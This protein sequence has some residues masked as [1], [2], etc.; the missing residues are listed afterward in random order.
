MGEF[1]AGVD[2]E[3]L[4]DVA[5]VVIDRLGTQEQ[6]RRRLSDGYAT[7]ELERD[8]QFLGCWLVNRGWVAPSQRL[9]GGGELDPR[10]LGPRSRT[11]LLERVDRGR[12]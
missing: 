3:L 12:S 7:G 10:A 5:E 11:Q 8:P 4:V 6:R 1:L 9:A 2:V